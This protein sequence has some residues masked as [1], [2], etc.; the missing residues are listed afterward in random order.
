MDLIF[1]I[2]MFDGSDTIY[3]LRE[4]FRVVAIEANPAL[5]ERVRG[6]L[7]S[8]IA[9]GQLTII[10]A[11]LSDGE[12]EVTLHVSGD[13]L[14]SSSLDPAAIAT[15]NPIGTYSVRGVTL[16]ELISE[17]GVPHYLKV[18]AEGA[19]RYCILPV[20]ADQR[21]NYLSFEA[22]PDMTELVDHATRVGYPG[23]SRRSGNAIFAR[24]TAKRWSGIA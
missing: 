17:F 18:D 4:G 21:P 20:T 13:D 15:R 9:S 14:G 2:G 7:S 22:G 23:C 3:Y 11:A 6:E 1:D 12:A 8:Y 10:N 16:P 24:S 5:V 19:D